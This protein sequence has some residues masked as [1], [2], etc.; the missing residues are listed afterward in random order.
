MKVADII[1]IM[2]EWA[3]PYLVDAWDNTGFQIGDLKRDIAKILIALDLD[4]NILDMA[5]KYDYDMIITHHPTIFKPLKSITS[6]SYK[7]RLVL[8]IIK[9]NIVVY[10][11][12]S[13]LD[14]AEEGVS[15][16]LAD[17]LGLRD[18]E[19]LKRVVTQDDNTYGYGR[20]GMVEHMPLTEYLN[21]V[22]KKLEVDSI[23]VYG[24]KDIEINRVAVCGGSGSDFIYDA[25]ASGADIYIT[26][27]IKYH[28]AQLGYE[29][30]L[31]IVDAGHF[32]TEKIV[33]P[34]IKKRLDE[35][36]NGEVSTEVIMESSLPMMVY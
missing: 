23:I 31:T 15:H 33:L 34:A 10:N 29:L 27:D 7:G 8:D 11:A 26:G 3:K 4:R 25:Y 20:I 32:N 22:K 24:D 5:I 1:E 30:G 17:I 14:M 36:L 35:K 28:D 13:N 21:I 2:E 16:Q 9:N 18:T 6:E 12:H 19:T